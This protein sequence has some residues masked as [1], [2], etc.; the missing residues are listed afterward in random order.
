MKSGSLDHKSIAVRGVMRRADPSR[1]LFLRG[2]QQP[3][4]GNFVKLHKLFSEKK[5]ST[6][7]SVMVIDLFKV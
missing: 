5:H 1:F 3:T 7:Y 6:N 2:E 4:L